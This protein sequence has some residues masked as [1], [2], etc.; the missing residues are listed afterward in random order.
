MHTSELPLHNLLHKVDGDIADKR[1]NLSVEV[2]RDT[3][4]TVGRNQPQLLP[5]MYLIND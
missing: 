1:N 2:V 5:C 3:A 4:R